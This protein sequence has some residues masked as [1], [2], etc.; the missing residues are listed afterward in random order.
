M[1]TISIIM[2]VVGG[3]MVIINN[4]HQNMSIADQRKKLINDEAIYQLNGQLTG[5]CQMT[6]INHKVIINNGTAIPRH[7]TSERCDTLTFVNEDVNS[8]AITFGVHSKHE[9]YAGEMEYSL[10]PG[11]SKTITLSEIG[12]FN[13]HDHLQPTISGSFS[14]L[15]DIKGR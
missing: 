3:S 7:I 11:K 10:R 8:H 15:N 9:S 1:A 2:V 12:G 5:A 14:V 4:L 6:Y 13:F